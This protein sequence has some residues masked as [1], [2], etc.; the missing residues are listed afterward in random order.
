MN[1]TVPDSSIIR[2]AVADA[3]AHR[4]STD[5]VR[6]GLAAHIDALVAELRDVTQAHADALEAYGDLKGRTCCG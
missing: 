2:R 4:G 6:A 1:V 5:G 3:D